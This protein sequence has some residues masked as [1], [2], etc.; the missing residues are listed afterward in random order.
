MTGEATAPNSVT[1]LLTR[2]RIRGF[3]LAAG[4][5]VLFMIGVH[6]LWHWG[7]PETWTTPIGLAISLLG[8]PTATPVFLFVMAASLAFSPGL[9]VGTL[10]A[11]GAW[12]LVLGYVL[13]VLRGVLPASIGMA[14]GF[15]TQQQIEPFTP[16]WLLTSVDLHHVTGMSLLL[17]AVLVRFRPDWRYVAVAVAIGLSGPFLRGLSFGTPLLDAPLTPI[18]GGAEN[19]FYAAIPWVFFPLVGAAFGRLLATARDR[20]RVFRLAGLLG[21]GLAVGGGAWI[22]ASG[23]PLDVFTY[24]RMPPPFIVGTIGV[25]LAWLALCDLVARRASID[26]RLGI[27]YH[28]SDRVIPMYFMHWIVVGWGVAIVGFRDLPL[29][30]ILVATS[31]AVV[32]TTISSRIAIGIESLPWLLR[33]RL[34]A[35]RGGPAIPIPVM[36]DQRIEVGPDLVADPVPADA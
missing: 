7:S 24:W 8:G 11:R 1:G 29:P 22:L 9:S 19:V 32:V 31:G 16:W 13:N 4:L 5:S 6:D 21:I 33:A 35:A 28:W 36:P 14:T 2:E 15:I 10:A 25:V 30:W 17:L 34:R 27:V 26:R 3:E 23:L 18:L 12:L 20:A